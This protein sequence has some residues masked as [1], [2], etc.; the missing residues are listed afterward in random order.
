MPELP[1]VEVFARDFASRGLNRKIESVD[2]RD[3]DRLRGSAPQDLRAALNGYAFETVK[4]HGKVL[5]V[6][7]SCGWWL[8]MHFGMTG[9]T[10][11]YDDPADEPGH[12]RLVVGFADG[13]FFAFDNQRKLGWLE[14]T[15]DVRAYLRSQGIGPDALE[16]DEAAFREV[17]SGTRGSVKPALMDQEKI[18]GIGNV[19]SDEILFQAGIAPEHKGNQLDGQQLARLFEATRNVLR[20]AVECRADPAR[21]PDDW[22]T[23]RREDGDDTCPRCGR[24]LET[25]KVGG[26]T[27][28]FCSHCQA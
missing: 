17:I 22:L 5:F 25:C 27:A 23:P 28:H 14:L 1:D 20:Q 4:R 7:V 26:R 19:Y 18:A 3:P 16:L 11:F 8:V 15:D 13:G 24:P 12:A 10:A 6:K 21:M 2:L 9:F